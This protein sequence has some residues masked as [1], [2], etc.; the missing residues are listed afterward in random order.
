MH[1]GQVIKHE[2]CKQVTIMIMMMMTAIHETLT[3]FS[4]CVSLPPPP[5]QAWRFFKTILSSRLYW[6]KEKLRRFK[7]NVI[8]QQ[9]CIVLLSP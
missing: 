1:F 4:Q 8:C 5:P 6:A 3:T 7:E 9:N 2:V